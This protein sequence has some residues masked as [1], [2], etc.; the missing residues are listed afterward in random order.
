MSKLKNE[1]EE[2]GLPFYESNYENENIEAV[3]LKVMFYSL[4]DAYYKLD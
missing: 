3:L 1:A 2:T 4:C